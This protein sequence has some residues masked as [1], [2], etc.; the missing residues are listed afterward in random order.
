MASIRL[1]LFEKIAAS[2]TLLMAADACEKRA[3]YSTGFIAA[4]GLAQISPHAFSLE[5]PFVL[6]LLMT[7]GKL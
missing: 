3:Q 6:V 1:S 4:A 5:I 7:T 2:T